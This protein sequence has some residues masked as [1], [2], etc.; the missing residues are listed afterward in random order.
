MEELIALAAVKK[1]KKKTD[2]RKHEGAAVSEVDD[3]QQ[4]IA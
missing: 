1:A 3:E 4:L 2:N